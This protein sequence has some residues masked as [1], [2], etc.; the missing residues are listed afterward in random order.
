[1]HY[2]LILKIAFNILQK[3]H[4]VKTQKQLCQNV[5]FIKSQKCYLS[6]FA[7]LARF[8]ITLFQKNNSKKSAICRRQL[9]VLASV[10]C[11]RSFSVEK[12]YFQA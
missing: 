5:R 3:V 10:G 9:G 1:M 8:H 2:K 11:E 7:D 6:K 4:L 12:C